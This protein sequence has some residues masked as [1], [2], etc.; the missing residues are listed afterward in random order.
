MRTGSIFFALLVVAGVMG[1]S[2]V[3][4]PDERAT[5]ARFH[6]E[7]R[8]AIGPRTRLP[9]SETE[10]TIAA[11]PVFTEFDLTSVAIVETEL[12]NCLS[13]QLTAAAARD[14]HRLSLVNVGQ[15]LVL[16]V[17]G[18]AMGARRIEQ[19][20]DDGVLLVFIEMPDDQLPALK[21][22]LLKT[23]EDYQRSARK[24]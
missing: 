19:P 22:A 7:S 21:A 17:D 2:T 11:K 14:L 1:C 12:G 13:F 20:I 15:R 4:S 16:T 9:Q 10:I 3:S 23:A 8:E 18:E 6:L 5:M 24:L